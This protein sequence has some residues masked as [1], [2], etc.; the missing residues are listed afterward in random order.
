MAIYI[1]CGKGQAAAQCNG[2]G[3]KTP[4]NPCPPPSIICPA[5]VWGVCVTEAD[6]RMHI[7]TDRVPPRP[8]GL[9]RPQQIPCKMAKAVNL[10]SARGAKTISVSSGR[11]LHSL[12]FRQIKLSVIP[13]D[14]QAPQ[15]DHTKGWDEAPT[16]VAITVRESASDTS[17]KR[18]CFSFCATSSSRSR[19]AFTSVARAGEREYSKLFADPSRTSR[20]VHWGATI[21]K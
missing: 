10:A 18:L 11:S 3:G 2:R 17:G 9:C 20:I 12:T 19:G 5:P 16:D 4:A 15:A 21:E 6:V 7:V 8:A 14:P 13:D 1:P